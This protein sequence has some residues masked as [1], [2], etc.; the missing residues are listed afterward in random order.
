MDATQFT[1]AD[2]QAQINQ[3]LRRLLRAIEAPAYV[4]DQAQKRSF[5]REA[6]YLVMRLHEFGL[7]SQDAADLFDHIS[8][9]LL[10][11]PDKALVRLLSY[12][13][14]FEAATRLRAPTASLRRLTE[15]ETRIVLD[16]QDLIWSS[17]TA[18]SPVEP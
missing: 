11:Y 16:Y 8:V 6:Y 3:Y 2:S 5:Y 1:P 18:G 14:R 4:C 7:L 9:G 12:K 10:G 13:A 17:F 15:E